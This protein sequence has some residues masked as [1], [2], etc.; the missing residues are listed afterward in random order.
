M[1]YWLGIV[2]VAAVL[3]TYVAP[4]SFEY[5]ALKPVDPKGVSVALLAKGVS[6]PSI[7]L[8]VPVPT[9]V[10]LPETGRAIGAGVYAPQPPYG[11]AF[12]MMLALDEAPNDFIEGYKGKLASAGLTLESAPNP[13]IPT[14]MAKARFQGANKESTRHV[15]LALRGAPGGWFMQITFWHGLAP[16]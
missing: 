4:A 14:D 8:L 16:T 1:W 13:M 12:S 10:V 7:G 15:F 3:A 6:V 11:P 9:W 2:A 5:G